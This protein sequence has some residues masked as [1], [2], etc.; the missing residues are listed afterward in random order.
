MNILVINGSPKGKNSI[1]LQT[2]L[3]LEKLA[4][5][6]TFSFLHAGQKIKYYEKN[7]A[8]AISMIKNADLIIF[9]YPVYTFIAPSQL[10]HFINLMK[11][12][13]E[14]FSGKFVTQISTSKHFYDTT[15]HRYIEENCFDMGMKVIKGLSADMDDLTTKKG[16]KE[17]VAFLK[18]ALW[19]VNNDVYE[20]IP[21][22]KEYKETEYLS[23]K[24]ENPD[25]KSGTVALVCDVSENDEKLISMIEDFKE[26][27][28]Y[29]IKEINI[30]NFDFSGGC[31]GCFNCAVDG[32]C[33]YKDGFDSF[34]R[35]EI[36]TSDAIVYAFSIED[37]SMGWRF[38]M[39]DDRQFCNGHRTVTEG[40]PF[41]YII[42]GNYENEE[43]LK[44]VIE[45]R[46]EVGH[47]FLAGVGHTPKTLS[48]MVKN[49]DY[50]IENKLVLPRNFYGVGG[51]KIFR[52]LIWVMRGLMK[53]DHEFYKKHG[54]YD[55]PH[56]QTGRML[57]MCL[58][59]EVMRNPKLK[60]KMN[61]KMTEGMLM[62]YKKVF[63][64]IDKRRQN[65]K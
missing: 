19:C 42:N 14:D 49:L 20:K 29:E 44:T 18:H 53:A 46:S 58:V 47:N 16:Q 38:K 13:G 34:L 3:F 15:A 4:L 11:N 65:K 25:V 36:Q 35:D 27:C 9:S 10:H 64:D 59:G 37:H 8:E 6:H 57:G 63:D 39:Y 28:P 41:G 50:A 33:I 21:D 52:D 60:A 32:K 61:G 30:R 55:F 7:M 2:S 24:S 31:L 56:K 12:C 48:D 51:M 22:K 62:P 45:G 26:K 40:T 17:A 54:V 5:K 23:L 1:T 43:N